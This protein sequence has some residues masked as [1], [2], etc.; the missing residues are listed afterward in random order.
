M[1]KILRKRADTISKTA[2]RI[3]ENS[4]NQTT[5]G[6]AIFVVLH[7]LGH[8]LI[9]RH[10]IPFSGRE[11]DTADQFAAYIIMKLNNPNIYLGAANF[12][13][14]PSRMLNIFGKR[15]LTDEHGLNVQRR[16]QLVCW[17]YG[18][19]PRTMQQFAAHLG[20]SENRLQ[21]CAGEYKLL[22]ENTPRLFNAV[23]VQANPT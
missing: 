3:D 11:E 23:W 22:M 2:G 10:R 14:E 8:A 19:D 20:L 15:Q 18:R 9:D 5:S 21:R 6:E 7:E 17:G 4:I 13:S 16:A 1:E 12:F